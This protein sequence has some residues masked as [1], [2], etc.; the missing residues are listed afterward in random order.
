MSLRESI[1]NKLEAQINSWNK[2]LQEKKAKLE[3]EQ[4]DAKNQ[5][6][7]A[8]LKH[9]SLQIIEDLEDNIRKAKVKLDEIKDSSEDRLQKIKSDVEDWI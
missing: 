5:L 3:Q 9:D 6:A 7:G 8:D 1:S 4:A 2:Q